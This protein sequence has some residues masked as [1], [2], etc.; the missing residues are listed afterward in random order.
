MLTGTS[1]FARR[2]KAELACMVVLEDER[3]P[4]P[5]D[6]EKLGFSDDVWETLQR[7]W[8]KEPSARPPVDIVSA[9]LKR[10]AETWVVDATAFML[11]SRAGVDQV[12]NM[13]EDQA[14]EF[15]DK[16]DQVRLVGSD[17]SLL[18][19]EFLRRILSQTLNQTGISQSSGKSYLKHLQR[20]CGASG[21]L[22]ASFMLTDGFDHIDQRPFAN[23]GFADVY[24]ATYKGQMVVAKALKTTS[25]D[26]LENVHRV[27]GF[28]FCTAA[29][30]VHV[31]FPALREGGRRLEMA[32]TRK[33]TAI[34]RG[35]IRSAPL[36]DGICLDGKREYHDFPQRQ[37]Q[38]EPIQPRKSIVFCTDQHSFMTQLVDVANG[39]QYLHQHD[40]VHGDLKG[41]RQPL[42]SQHEVGLS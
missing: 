7:C 27:G 22:P 6:S 17:R 36:L 29:Q 40:F 32:S 26:D 5:R 30:P 11:A 31:S 3:P 42:Q 34:R 19:L 20:L 38:S 2:I 35:Y 13:K 10:A 18:P 15:A 37:S 21:I 8:E 14:K 41:V 39:L 25:M 4:R 12:M 33:H 16:L 24:K 9:C 1:P 28:V 23:G